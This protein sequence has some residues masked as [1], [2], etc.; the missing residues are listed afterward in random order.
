[1]STRERQPEWEE[2]L[3]GTQYLLFTLLFLVIPFAC[4]LVSSV[5]YYCWKEQNPRK[6]NQ[7]NVLG[8]IIFGVNILMYILYKFVIEDRL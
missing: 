4:V 2:G 5:L 3:T 6:A 1:M 7:I 8:F